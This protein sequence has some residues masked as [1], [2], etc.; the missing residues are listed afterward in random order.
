[1]RSACWGAISVRSLMTMRPL[2]VSITI[3]FC[4]ARLA[5]SG[6]AIAGAAQ[7][8]ATITARTRTMKTPDRG[9][10]WRVDLFAGEFG[11]EA[12][13]DRFRHERR[14]VAAHAGDLAYQCGGDRADGGRGRNEHRVDLRRHGF[15]HA[16]DLHLEIKVGAVAQ[17]PNHDGRAVF[18]RRYDS[19]IV[20]G[21]AV[22]GAAGF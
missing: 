8:S 2:V 4:L 13:G 22:E 18:L 21:R 12:A 9:E 20:I 11:L 6:C 14:P 17:A 7:I 19:E 5:G 15:V 3:A 16:G 10:R 1:M